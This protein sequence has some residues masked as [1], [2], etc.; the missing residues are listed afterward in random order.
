MANNN[1]ED[2]QEY[3]VVFKENGTYKRGTMS[4]SSIYDVIV[5]VSV[6]AD[7]ESVEV[8]VVEGGRPFKHWDNV[9]GFTFYGNDRIV[10]ENYPV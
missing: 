10:A 5:N 3:L 1:K 7:R 2:Y 6:R 8:L 4:G 9:T